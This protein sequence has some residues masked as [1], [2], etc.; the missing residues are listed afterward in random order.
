MTVLKR[1]DVDPRGIWTVAAVL[2]SA[3]RFEEVRHG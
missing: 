1:G 2:V 3:I